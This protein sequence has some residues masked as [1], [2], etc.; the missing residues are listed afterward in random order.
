MKKA[1]GEVNKLI[2]TIALDVHGAGDEYRHK[3][4]FCVVFIRCN[5]LLLH[6]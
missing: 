5:S 6:R 4:Y 2:D 1:T 3:L